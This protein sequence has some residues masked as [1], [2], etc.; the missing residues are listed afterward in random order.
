EVHEQIA[1]ETL[2]EAIAKLPEQERDVIEM[3][4]G[5]GDQEPQTLSQ[6]GRMLGVSTERARQIEE[7][8]LRR[9]SQRPELLALREAA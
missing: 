5:A 6:A 8:A 2:L 4:F 3:R 7:R 1:S 9:L